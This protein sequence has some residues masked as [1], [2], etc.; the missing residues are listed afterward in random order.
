MLEEDVHNKHLYLARNCG[1]T[2]PVKGWYWWWIQMQSFNTAF[3]V[4]LMVKGAGVTNISFNQLVLLD[5][6]QLAAGATGLFSQE[7]TAAIQGCSAHGL[8]P[9]LGE[10][11]HSAGGVAPDVHQ[12][13]PW[14]YSYWVPSRVLSWEEH[15]LAAFCEIFIEILVWEGRVVSQP[16]NDKQ[17]TSP[18][19]GRLTHRTLSAQQLRMS[20]T[21]EYSKNT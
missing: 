5:T 18:N 3:I 2:P 17:H 6:L 20:T 9:F 10:I 16:H 21:S 19:T 12:Y 11:T 13:L 14:W 7:A 1:S 15:K 8:D 4:E